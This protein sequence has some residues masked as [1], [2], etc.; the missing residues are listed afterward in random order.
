MRV[1]GN[2]SNQLTT[3]QSRQEVP[4]E[5]WMEVKQMGIQV[6]QYQERLMEEVRTLSPQQMK[7][8]LEFVTILKQEPTEETL[9]EML[10][11][12]GVSPEKIEQVC[13][14]LRQWGLVTPKLLKALHT[15]AAAKAPCSEEQRVSK[16]LE[17][18][19]ENTIMEAEKEELHLL[20][21]AGE[22]MNLKKAGALVA[23][24]HLT[25]NLPSWAR[26]KG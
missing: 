9:L 24:K 11:E 26:R 2:N 17:K 4:L 10:G 13:E 22:R 14:R 25:G 16:L 23:L 8:V 20:V 5:T 6:T 1:S 21:M 7:T 15:I 12:P 19:R 3:H 18:N